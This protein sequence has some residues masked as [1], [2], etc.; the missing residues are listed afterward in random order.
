MPRRTPFSRPA[1]RPATLLVAAGVLAGLTACS[2]PPEQAAA[3]APPP[4]PAAT[5]AVTSAMPADIAD[6]V[7][8][9]TGEQTRLSQ[10]LDAFGR[11]AADK[12]LR[13]CLA[14]HRTPAPP[15]EPPAFVRFSDIPDLP[16]IDRNGFNG[17]IVPGA[18]DATGDRPAE[19]AGRGIQ[20]RC[21]KTGTSVEQSLRTLYVDV[22][23]SWFREESSLRAHP[24]VLAALRSFGPCMADRQIEAPDENA[25]FALVDQRM[26]AGDT[27]GER[28][29]ARA[30]SA[31]MKPAE[32]VRSE[33]RKALGTRFRADHRQEIDALNTALPAKIREFERRYGVRI[34][35]PVL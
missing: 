17:V 23:G 22:Q 8:P 31:C 18:A 5:V 25:F 20:D 21:M 9:T 29:L 2:A 32:D 6:M 26:Q 7:V 28:T 10:G 15:H 12:A 16:F 19:G 24:R 13:T 4:H 34:S 30:Y 11:L 33:L 3:P 1:A 35:F 27:T 14:E